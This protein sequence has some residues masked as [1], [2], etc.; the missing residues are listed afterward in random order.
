M[1]TESLRWGDA[2]KGRGVNKGSQGGWI[3]SFLVGK[4]S[5]SQSRAVSESRRLPLGS[6]SVSDVHV[7]TFKPAGCHHPSLLQTQGADSQSRPGFGAQAG[8]ALSPP[9]GPRLLE[10]GTP[11]LDEEADT[12]V[13]QGGAFWGQS[14][15]RVKEALHEVVNSPS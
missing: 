13:P 4:C 15:H 10:A 2:S 5:L 1:A 8:V 14:G 11:G 3:C 12:R 9:Q 6:I 7:S